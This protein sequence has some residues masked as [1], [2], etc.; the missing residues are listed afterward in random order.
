MRIN[1][2]VE[3]TCPEHEN[4]MFEHDVD[5]ERIQFQY[6]VDSNQ[7]QGTPLALPSTQPYHSDSKEEMA[8]SAK[9]SSSES[10]KLLRAKLEE[11]QMKVG[12]LEAEKQSKNLDA[13]NL[14]NQVYQGPQDNQGAKSN[15]DWSSINMKIL[16][17]QEEAAEV[18]NSLRV[19]LKEA[20]RKIEER[21]TQLK[22]L[23][24][25]MKEQDIETSAEREKIKSVRVELDLKNK[26]F[27]QMNKYISELLR[28]KAKLIAINKEAKAEPAQ[29]DLTDLSEALRNLKE[30]NARLSSQ[31]KE[32]MKANEVLRKQEAPASKKKTMIRTIRTDSHEYLNVVREISKNIEDKERIEAKIEAF[33]EKNRGFS[34]L[35]MNEEFNYAKAKALIADFKQDLNQLHSEVENS[36]DENSSSD[37]KEKRESLEKEYARLSSKISD[38][39]IL[40]SSKLEREA[41]NQKTLQS[42]NEKITQ[43]ESEKIEFQTRK[44]ETGF[45]DLDDKDQSMKDLLKNA[46]RTIEDLQVKV[47]ESYNWGRVMEEEVERLKSEAQ[48]IS[49]NDGEGENTIV[50]KLVVEK[51]QV[52]ETLNKKV[53]E[54]DLHESQTLKVQGDLNSEI[55]R[56]K[57]IIENQRFELEQ[58]QN[59]LVNLKSTILTLKKVKENSDS[60]QT[61]LRSKLVLLEAENESLK[62][63]SSTL[64]ENEERLRQMI[65]DMEAAGKKLSDSSLNVQKNQLFEAEAAAASLK[66]L[67]A[68]KNNALSSLHAEIEKLKQKGKEG[69]EKIAKMAENDK[70]IGTLQEKIE[71]LENENDRHV[72]NE[73]YYI[74]SYVKRTELDKAN[75]DLTS[76]KS[77]NEKLNDTIRDLRQENARL[78]KEADELRVSAN[79]HILEVKK[80]KT[81]IPGKSESPAQQNSALEIERLKSEILSFRKQLSAQQQTH[82]ADLKQLS[83]Q[84]QNA[85]QEKA[86]LIAAQNELQS[87]LVSR[88]K[89]LEDL[90]GRISL[91]QMPAPV[92]FNTN[93]GLKLPV[94]DFKSTEDLERILSSVTEAAKKYKALLESMGEKISDKFPETAETKEEM[95]DSIEFAASKLMKY[96]RVIDRLW[97]SRR[98][99]LSILEVQL[100]NL[101][102]KSSNSSPEM[103]EVLTYAKFA[104]S[105]LAD[106]EVVT[107]GSSTEV[108]IESIGSSNLMLVAQALFKAQ[109]TMI[110]RISEALEEKNRQLNLL[111]ITNEKVQ[112]SSKGKTVSVE[113]Y[114]KVLEAAHEMN[115]KIIKTLNVRNK[116]TP[117]PDYVPEAQTASTP[118]EYLSNIEKAIASANKSIKKVGPVMEEIIESSK[119][120]IEQLRKEMSDQESLRMISILTV[121]NSNLN[122]GHARHH[123]I[124]VTNENP[125]EV[126]KMISDAI[127]TMGDQL[128]SIKD[129]NAKL[130]DDNQRLETI[131]KVV[132]DSTVNA[133]ESV[134]SIY[135]SVSQTSFALETFLQSKGVP[136]LETI[137]PKSE[138]A[139]DFVECCLSISHR[140]HSRITVISE[141]LEIKEDRIAALATE[142]NQSLAKMKKMHTSEEIQPLLNKLRAN[143]KSLKLHEDTLTG[144]NGNQTV[145]EIAPGLG[146]V[147]NLEIQI[148]FFSNTIKSLAQPI[149]NVMKDNKDL[150]TYQDKVKSGTIKEGSLEDFKK[151]YQEFSR[152]GSKLT[153]IKRTMALLGENIPNVNVY[154][155]TAEEVLEAMLDCSAK[156]LA[157]A[158]DIIAELEKSK[159]P[160]RIP[161][162]VAPADT[163]PIDRLVRI[164][165]GAQETRK[166]AFDTLKKSA[167][168]KQEFQA[169]TI[170]SKSEFL[171]EQE[172][173]KQ[174]ELIKDLVIRIEESKPRMEMKITKTEETIDYEKEKEQAVH[175]SFRAIIEVLQIY[176]TALYEEETSLI[177]ISSALGSSFSR[178]EGQFTEEDSEAQQKILAD[179][180]KSNR[181]K[182]S[183][184]KAMLQKSSGSSTQASKEVLQWLEN[185]SKS[186][187]KE[188]ED[189]TRKD[190]P[191]AKVTPDYSSEETIAS[192]CKK[193][194]EYFDSNLPLFSSGVSQIFKDLNRKFEEMKDDYDKVR[195]NQSAVIQT[196][197]K[198]I[199]QISSL[200]IKLMGAYV[201][202][203]H[204]HN[205]KKET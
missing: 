188:Y 135:D 112:S 57:G 119:A 153:T 36:V 8:I 122:K 124:I 82:E 95:I 47:E 174:F 127:V 44:N 145:P 189:A 31:L 142:M 80:L 87:Q 37:S 21:E 2:Q 81:E 181:Q 147:E 177:E 101:K 183:Q 201:F 193:Y 117:F 187:E 68:E 54:I 99:E 17:L 114:I 49:Q 13:R 83:A 157:A 55:L 116:G 129:A 144:R 132:P 190:F 191:S 152:M 100:K 33:E 64:K 70:L 143:N 94:V 60:Q 194:M 23:R 40:I 14:T 179:F 176:Q 199:S 93:D 69:S 71:Q 202:I 6:A 139:E 141:I 167:E 164:F 88:Q 26:S 97:K 74:E 42:L 180:K 29:T 171:L 79:D 104:T 103:Q 89:E 16:K 92:R 66:V 184:L 12:Q 50:R 1:V 198:Y 24:K 73:R 38:F 111:K 125:Q 102:T 98:D 151:I 200:R 130:Q 140:I 65:K 18:E 56:Q 77:L 158:D 53:E 58:K 78:K 62:S 161:K 138:S 172:I 85:E 186:F 205:Q 61:S 175:A 154:N 149:D 173:V 15:Q 107:V 148:E 22:S 30:E 197:E 105:R 168:S 90:N 75:S 28:E 109:D 133:S 3:F 108:N 34:K 192:S 204:L 159:D 41:A 67:V 165:D 5:G 72:R 35:E 163:E 123:S 166:V 118:D 136:A 128:T 51:Q 156:S 137:S 25:Q 84:L 32:L 110:Q 20:M 178:F 9:E 196:N 113:A 11:L 134:K 115:R 131:A 120:S 4:C 43:L 96:E 182:W 169:F 76:A 59:T 19:Q 91:L 170:D 146:A 86:R 106:L 185:F 126:A 52:E 160:K 121:V 46:Q 45:A 48:A 195:Q 10:E 27:D 155:K 150:K 39:E 7:Y 203:E 63:T 162:M